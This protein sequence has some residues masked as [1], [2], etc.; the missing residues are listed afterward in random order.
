MPPRES[1][2][3]PFG[4]NHGGMAQAG[5]QDARGALFQARQLISR[6]EID[7]APLFMSS[8]ATGGSPWGSVH[9][10]VKLGTLQMQ[11]C[12]PGETA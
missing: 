2:G 5:K 8:F 3:C 6:S 11:V 12:S 4:R 7:S 1:N 10:G 9:Q